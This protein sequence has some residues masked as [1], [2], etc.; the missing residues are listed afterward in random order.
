MRIHAKTIVALAAGAILLPG[1]PC[2][3]AQAQGLLNESGTS[4]LA[5]SFGTA[6]GPEALTV[7][8]WVVESTSGIYTYTYIVNNPSGDVLLNNN[9]TPTV[10]P[11]IVD[12]LALDFDATL[13]GAVVS[14]PTGGNGAYNFGAFGLYWD[15]SPGVVLAGASSGPLSFESDNPPMPGNASAS[16]DNPP[17]PWSSYPDGQQVPVPDGP[18]MVPEPTTAALLALAALLLPPFRSTVRK[19]AGSS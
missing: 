8:W 3:T 2:Q 1:L 11:E 5:D 17:S 7:S 9:G 16:D 10:T 14:G 13:P 6:A 15:L 19:K 12:S 4:V 18:G